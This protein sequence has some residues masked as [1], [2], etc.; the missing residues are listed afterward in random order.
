MKRTSA[1]HVIRCYQPL[2]FATARDQ[3]YIGTK[4]AVPKFSPDVIMELISQATEILKAQPSLVEITTPCTVVGDLHGNLRDLCRIVGPYFTDEKMKFLFLGDYV[5]RGAYSLEV[6]TL[7]YALMV[8]YPERFF[9]IRG[10]HE[11]YEPNHPCGLQH[12]LVFAYNNDKLLS[13]IYESFGYLPLAATINKEVF[14]VHGG[15]SPLLETLDDVRK[16][17]RPFYEWKDELV[18]DMLWSDP[19]NI[20]STFMDST[21]GIGKFYSQTAARKFLMTNGLKLLV[22]AHQVIDDGI[23]FFSPEIITVFSSSFYNQAAEVKA[24]ILV[25]HED[26]MI[27]PVYFKAHAEARRTYTKFQDCPNKTLRKFSSLASGID[28]SYINSLTS[29]AH[30]YK[31][32]VFKKK[33]RNSAYTAFLSTP[34]TPLAATKLGSLPV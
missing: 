1:D 4:M 23:D 11:L 28:A 20:I 31:S 10:N 2:L 13:P 16:I 22:R 6:I 5:D 7:L 3:V 34:N 17:Q 27:E 29:A 25:F 24:G 18:S 26:N 21:R 33:R 8:K 32:P 19:I 15:I 30:F 9:L 12:D 14:C